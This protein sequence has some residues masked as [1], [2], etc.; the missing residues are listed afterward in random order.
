MLQVFILRAVYKLGF[1]VMHSVR[2]RLSI[3][4]SASVLQARLASRLWGW[5]GARQL[6]RAE[7][8]RSTG[9][10]P[11]LPR[12]KGVL[13]QDHEGCRVQVLPKPVYTRSYPEIP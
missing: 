12:R 3:K 10:T 4:S 6:H 9:L 7:G 1:H 5:L 2:A 13:Q 8:H 11:A